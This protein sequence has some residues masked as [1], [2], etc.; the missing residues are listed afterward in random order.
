MFWEAKMIH[1][2]LSTSSKRSKNEGRDDQRHYSQ[3]LRK[4]KGHQEK[5]VQHAS[6]DG[7]L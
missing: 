7:L 2:F 6:P 5:N 4:N 3:F 1:T